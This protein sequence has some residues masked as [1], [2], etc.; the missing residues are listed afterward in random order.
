MNFEQVSD[1]WIEQY[2]IP[3]GKFNSI[4]ECKYT[5]PPVIMLTS[6]NSEMEAV[7]SLKAGA[8]DFVGKPYHPQV[9]LAHIEVVLKRTKVVSD[10]DKITYKEVTL[11]RLSGELEYQGK[12]IE[13]TRN[14]LRILNLLMS[15][16]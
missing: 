11:Y 7:M 12:R 10:M 5:I 16:P 13:L 14:E 6:Q 15:R 2:D 1:E 8:D 3:F 4:N 9:L